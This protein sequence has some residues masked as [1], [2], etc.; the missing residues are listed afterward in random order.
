M[1]ALQSR[2][3]DRRTRRALLGGIV[4]IS[5]MLNFVGPVLVSGQP[6]IPEPI[7]PAD[8]DTIITPTFSWL[9]ASG[10]AYYEVQVGPQ[11]DPHLAYWSGT[12]YNLNLTPDDADDF[13]NELLYWRVRAYDIDD[14]PGPWSS[15]VRFEKYI[16]APD[17]RSPPNHLGLAEPA[18][19]WDPVRGA[20]SYKVAFSQDPAFGTV[21]E[22]YE[23][24][25]TGLTPDDAIPHGTYY[26][27]VTGVDADGGEDHQGTPSEAGI[28]T[29]RIPAPIPVGPSDGITLTE[30]VFTWRAAEG[31]THY[32]VEIG[33][34]PGFDEVDHTYTTHNLSLTPDGAIDHGTFYWRVTGID[35]GD[36]AGT[37]SRGW[38]FFKELAPPALISPADGATVTVPTFRWAPAE[39]A[40]T[41]RVEV[42]TDPSFNYVPESYETDN[43][44]LTPEDVLA[45][46][47]YH[48]RVRAVDADGHAGS[49]SEAWTLMLS[50]AE[51]GGAAESTLQLPADGAS[52]AA[53]PTFRWAQVSGADT[54]RLEV[55]TDPDFDNLYDYEYVDYYTS[56]TPRRPYEEGT[57]HWRVEA[58]ADGDVLATSEARTFTKATTVPLAEPEDDVDL[59]SDPTF[60]WSDVVGANGY[61]LE[62]DTDPGF[63]NLY[64]YGYVDYTSHTPWRPYEEG[65]YYWRVKALNAGRVIAT[66]DARSFIKDTALHLR[67]PGEEATMS[68]NPTFQWDAVVGANRYKLEVD[69]DPGFDNLYD[70]GYVDYTSHTPG[71]PYEEGM[72]YWRVKALNAGNV[73]ATSDAHSFTKDVPPFTLA[74]PDG[75]TIGSDPTFSW[76][77]VVGADRY[78]LEVSE[79]PD[80][81]PT[82]DYAYMAYPSYTPYRPG[83]SK[84]VYEDSRY[85][86][87]IKAF[88]GG[89]LIATSL[90]NTFTKSGTQPTSTPIG[91]PTATP[92][93]SPTVTP[94]PPSTATP[95]PNPT[96]PGANPTAGPP[97][98]NKKILGNVAVCADAFEDL[99]ENRWRASGHIRLGGAGE[100]CAEASAELSAG[101]V[102]LD[103]GDQSI[104]GSSEAVVGLL[105]S[106]VRAAPVFAGSFSVDASTGSVTPL[107]VLYRLTRLGDLG[108][109]TGTPLADFSMNVLEGTVSAEARVS[110][111]AIEGVVPQATVGFT[112]HTTGEIDGD[113]GVGDLTFK[114]AA[115]TFSVESATFSYSPSAGGAFTIDRATVALPDM[116]STGV[117]S[118]GSI[119]GLLITAA[120]LEDISGGSM[121][122]SLPDLAVPGTGGKFELAGASVTLSLASGGQYMVHGEVGFSL[123]NIASSGQ[124]GKTYSGGLYAEFELDQDGLRYILMG[125]S[126]DPGIPIGQSGMALTG[127]EGRVSL[128]PVRVQVTG[129]LQSQLEVPPLGPVVGGEPSVWVQFEKPYEVGVSGSLQVLIFDAAEAS[130]VINQSDGLVGEAHISYAP[131]ALSGDANL[132]VWRSDGEFHFTG[133]AGVTVGFEKG[134]LWTKCVNY[135]VGKTCVH[136]PPMAVTLAE[137]DTS[138]GEFCENQSCTSS[139]YGLKGTANIAG[140]ESAFFLDTTGEL[141]VGDD[142]EDYALLDQPSKTGL[143]AEGRVTTTPYTDVRPVEIGMTDQ[144]LFLLGWRE[145]APTF[146]LRDPHGHRVDPVL[147]P[148]VTYTSV[149]TNAFYVVDDPIGGT[150]QIDVGNLTGDEYYVLNVLGSDVPPSVTVESVAP[151]GQGAY[152]I[153]WTADELDDDP[154]LALYYDTDDKDADG[155]LIADGLDPAAGSYTWDATHVQTGDYYVY[156]RIDDLKNTPVT[157]YSTETASVVDHEAPRAPTGLT[158][159]VPPPWISISACWER[160]SD[161]DAV[162]YHVYYGTESGF[163]DLGRIDATNLT[164]ATLPVQPGVDTYYLAVASYDSS[165]NQ[166]PLSEEVEITVV[167]LHDIYLPLL[168]RADG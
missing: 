61:K 86:W 110:V 19:A 5:V 68:G 38:S 98:A 154:T 26:W 76:N 144:A 47:T 78:R 120:G 1:L 137:V 99:G 145:G 51:G 133:S 89:R 36:H 32:Q 73:I 58:R 40:A 6:S 148:G 42:S 138:F 48:W 11:S 22:T 57:Y 102:T 141:I 143:M 150:W 123:P 79:V 12:T 8:G 159:E 158:A 118:E 115:L 23:T 45:P 125:G 107:N 41:Y 14:N 131:F 63:D 155:T 106:G 142:A 90:A 13:P 165:D 24:Q 74:P 7:L 119:S 91:A 95:G 53:D 153:H 139:I 29:K 83:G 124:P 140:W 34:D 3:I 94:I 25:A 161:P 21:D 37:P 135:Y 167:R 157:A 81:S 46:D 152:T 105:L 75:A 66:S 109:N 113:L 163:Y 112:L 28:F 147:D 50:A 15:R 97:P 72:Y 82:Y 35:A 92:T 134:A 71:R 49:P 4:T 70:Y 130:L 60:S 126:V 55:D 116:L 65:T 59:S 9:P 77:Y 62:V 111:Y 151:D 164:C 104:N 33:R 108:V 43:T 132:H 52:L 88:H 31:A 67:V 87:R 39:G 10:A 103:Y 122:L 96:P 160:S 162:G 56:H 85:Y 101:T 114:A 16:P 93:P 166:G 64:D 20:S 100:P 127:M 146:N 69:T 121:T 80:F 149:L 84:D 54:Y 18:V 129:T 30:P 17:L 156:A 2:P 44:T 168:L 117:G 128:E 27:R 136:V